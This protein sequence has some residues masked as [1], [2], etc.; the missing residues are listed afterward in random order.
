MEKTIPVFQLSPFF[1]SAVTGTGK[2]VYRKGDRAKLGKSIAVRLRSAA[3]FQLGKKPVSQVPR[4]E[5]FGGA[6]V[7][8]QEVAGGRAAFACLC[9]ES[10]YPSRG[11]WVRCWLCS[12][13]RN[14]RGGKSY[15]Y[16]VKY[17][18]ELADK[19]HWLRS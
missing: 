9:G 13:V 8:E 7:I 5:A 10:C 3:H 11:T 12:C 19:T 15:Y 17:L 18:Q 6:F 1:L 2:W 4:A 14:G 16:T